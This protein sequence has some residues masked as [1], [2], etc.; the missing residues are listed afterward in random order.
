MQKRSNIPLIHQANCRDN[1][2]NN[3]EINSMKNTLCPNP[4]I[5]RGK[6]KRMARLKLPA[7]KKRW[8]DR[9]LLGM[10]R[11]YSGSFDIVKETTKKQEL[12]PQ[13]K[14]TLHKLL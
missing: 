4:G 5:P 9:L 7:I 11:I 2:N 13:S 1:N 8:E 14:S 3:R 10:T 6:N 12:S